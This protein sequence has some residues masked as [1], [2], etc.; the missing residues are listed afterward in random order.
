MISIKKR[1]N[2]RAYDRL[3][4]VREA[5][6]AQMQQQKQGSDALSTETVTITQ[7]SGERGIP[8]NQDNSSTIGALIDSLGRMCRQAG[9]PFTSA[10]FSGDE[11]QPVAVR[12]AKDV[13][14]V[15][16]SPIHKRSFTPQLKAPKP[17]VKRGYWEGTLQDYLNLFGKAY[18]FVNSE[19]DVM[20]K[21]KYVGSDQDLEDLI[22]NEKNQVAKMS[23]VCHGL[24]GSSVFDL[25]P[26]A[27]VNTTKKDIDPSIIRYYANLIAKL[28][29][30]NK[31]SNTGTVSM[32]RH[33]GQGLSLYGPSHMLEVNT[34]ATI[35]NCL[36]GVGLRQGVF[37]L[38]ELSDVWIFPGVHAG[39]G[40]E[41][42]RRSARKKTY[43]KLTGP[44]SSFVAY[45]SRGV[46]A[47]GRS[48]CMMPKMFTCATKEVCSGILGAM[49]LMS[50][51][52]LNPTTM[53]KEMQDFQ[54]RATNYRKPIFRVSIDKSRFDSTCRGA[55]FYELLKQMNVA[56]RDIDLLLFEDSGGILTSPRDT[57]AA[58]SF[59][60]MSDGRDVPPFRLQSGGN[61]T[62]IKGHSM[63]DMICLEFCKKF[64]LEKNPTERR[65]IDYLWY[66]YGD[67]GIFMT[68]HP[69][70][71]EAFKQHIASYGLVT[72]EDPGLIYLMNYFPDEG[73]QHGLL[74]RRIQN[75]F[76]PEVFKD[77]PC[78]NAIAIA[79]HN[80]TMASHPS[81]NRW[82]QF[83]DSLLTQYRFAK[84]KTV[85]DCTAYANTDEAKKDVAEYASKAIANAAA[86][87]DLMSGSMQALAIEGLTDGGE[88]TALAALLGL[89]DLVS[90]VDVS[91]SKSYWSPDKKKQWLDVIR[92]WNE[93]TLSGVD[94][95]YVKKASDLLGIKVS[96]MPKIGDINFKL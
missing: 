40:Y 67:D 7:L 42:Y 46:I 2:P 19:V 3:L 86:V 71:I 74:A 84:H 89:P 79:A 70:A 90:K 44:S 88:D 23:L 60:A 78:I 85:A 63:N 21:R 10:R 95:G 54:R 94:R 33:K 83:M 8:L 1:K 68:T 62:T 76:Q 31:E 25:A 81:Y 38:A 73:V 77:D 55:F 35:A 91:V 27:E 14:P 12:Y 5:L 39:A 92:G 56:T 80:L 58:C 64:F 82:V 41:G 16:M 69:N 96:T 43:L 29:F 4:D 65:G 45:E 17:I 11:K 13:S 49:N 6:D 15:T 52:G 59:F 57:S 9:L 93:Q 37:S 32:P 30:S 51:R 18:D 22:A 72:S 24:F 28:G 34:V 26:R 50:W 61:T 47:D 20:S 53:R 75:F 66:V 87:Q 36:I 48:I